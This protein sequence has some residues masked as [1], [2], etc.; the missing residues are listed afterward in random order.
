MATIGEILDNVQMQMHDANVGAG[1]E[2]RQILVV[3]TLLVVLVILTWPLRRILRGMR[4]R[5]RWTE[6]RAHFASAGIFP[7]Y[8]IVR[9][10][11]VNG[12]RK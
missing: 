8:N 3:A 5:E 6:S 12:K 2:W 11:R 1:I 9:R 10:H 7:T 4:N